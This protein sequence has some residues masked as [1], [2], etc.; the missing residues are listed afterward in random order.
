MPKKPSQASELYI[1]CIYSLLEECRPYVQVSNAMAYM[2]KEEIGI[3]KRWTFERWGRGGQKLD[4]VSLT[5]RY[6]V[7]KLF[8]GSLQDSNLMVLRLHRA[9]T[10]DSW[11]YLISLGLVCLYILKQVEIWWGYTDASL[12]TDWITDRQGKIK[13]L[14]LLRSRDGALT[15]KVEIWSGVTNASQTHSHTDRLWKKGLL[16]SL[17]VGLELS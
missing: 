4:P 2:R 14:K 10:V 6:E 13:L 1:W 16:S 17:E 9:V 15:Q 3:K 5:V 8:T 11:W 7:I 12:D